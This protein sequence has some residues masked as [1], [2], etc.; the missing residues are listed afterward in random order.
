MLT[1]RDVTVDAVLS[2][3]SVAFKSDNYLAETIM[4]VVTVTKQSGKYFKFDK[5]SLRVNKTRRAAGSPSNE[6]EH[7]MTTASYFTE[8]HALKEKI[9]YEV[10][11]QAENAINPEMD[12]TEAI[13]EMLLVDKEVSLATSMA[14]TAVITQN[15]TLSGTSQ[16]SDYTNSNPFGDINTAI[17]T[18]QA[19]IGRRPNTLIFG[20]QTFNTLISHPDIVDRIKYTVAGAASEDLIARLFNVEKVLIGSALKN[21][22]TEGQTDA[23]GF[24]W[25]KHAW[26]AYIAP[27]ARLKQ[28]TLGYHFQYKTR[29][30]EKWEDVDAQSRW[31]RVGDNYDQEF[32]AAEAAYLIKNATA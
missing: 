15:T 19:A 31:V 6:V 5:S 24:I 14:D 16:W 20:Q 7:G 27:S 32:V 11:D 22:A 12:A 23:L 8:D 26:A 21:T 30:V 9:P 28:V 18:V 17:S 2:N 4:P 29:V 13:T 25:G 10:I 1:P 3:V